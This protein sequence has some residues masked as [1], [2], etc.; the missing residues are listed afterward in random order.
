MNLKMLS[1][2][3]AL[4]LS[5]G[6]VAFA[7]S[8]AAAEIFVK[9]VDG[10]SP[11]FIRGVDVSSAL[12]LERSG[13]VFRDVA[14]K[15]ADLFA[16]LAD[17]GVNSVRV[18]VWNDPFSAAG[19]G[20]GGGNCDINAAIEIGKR[21]T[22]RGISV[23]LDFHYSDFWADPAKQ[24]E[25]RA[26]KGM[27]LDKKER[28]LYAYT[29]DCLTKALRAGVDVRMVQIGNE[30]TGTFCGEKNW[31]NIGRLMNAGS[32]AV[33]ETAKAKKKDIEIAIHFTNPEKDGE[34]ERYVKILEKQKVDY[35]VFASSW[36]PWWH[37]TAENF[38]AVLS[39][40]AEISGKKVM[41][42]EVSY[43][44]TYENGD[45]SG[46]TISEETVCSKPY[47]ITV[48]G[49]ANAVRDAIA[50]VAAVGKKGI[51][52]YYWEPAW[53]PVPG[54]DRA[55]QQALWERDG[56]GWASSYASEYDP[57]D[58]GKFYGGTSWD[59]QAMFS[60]DGRPLA[61]LAVWRLV[62]SGAVAPLRPDFVAEPMIRARIGDPVVLPDRVTVL[63]NDGAS[64]SLPVAWEA[65]GTRSGTGGDGAVVALG[66]MGSRGVA[67]YRVKGSV[68]DAGVAALARVFVVE[69]NYVENASFEEKDLSMWKIVNNDNITT[70]LYVQDKVSD[71]KTGNRALHFWSKNRV[72][73]TVE[74]TITGLAPGTYKFSLAIHGGDAKNPDMHIYAVS[75]GKIYTL[76]T[77]VDGWRNF[78][79]P[80]IGTIAVTDGTVTVGASISCDAKGWGSLDDFALSPVERN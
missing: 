67:E 38:A 78:R 68:R 9:K 50:A 23:L 59:N 2:S 19:K 41:C 11:D 39:R 6:C 45:F 3:L 70:E 35:D 74:Q 13:V 37:G 15:P 77:D 57:A 72:S 10:L 5:L 7:Q 56:S 34:Y 29:K 60:F 32:R 33:R 71:A 79:A 24:Q 31:I 61:S 73:F 48:Q 4:A 47:P 20:F 75:G 1:L 16:V 14:G 49:Q 22:A 17:H 21:A 36:Y 43:A 28:A 54:G 55:A 30:T 69:K 12:A 64:E 76:K 80:T 26:W 44:Y 25:P 27:K 65:S 53:L 58:A 51:G 62:D 18:R 66:V 40:V 8:A 42:A 63:Y 46:N 52:V